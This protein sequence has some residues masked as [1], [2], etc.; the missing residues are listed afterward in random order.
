[1]S[2]S[3]SFAIKMTSL[4]C[5]LA[6]AATWLIPNNE[7]SGAK[8]NVQDTMSKPL[9]Q[10]AAQTWKFFLAATKTPTSL[11]VDRIDIDN[12]GTP[13]VAGSNT[14]PTNIGMY[15]MSLAAA[16]D[17]GLLSSGE[18]SK[19]LD[20]V[21]K[22]IEHL[23]KWNGFLYNWYDTSDGSVA[24]GSNARFV[25]TVDN[26]WY[27]AGLIVAR[28]AF[29]QFSPRLT[30][31]F[32]AMD[33]SRLYDRSI[34]QMYGGF[35][36]E[37]NTLADW[38]YGNLNTESRVADYVAIGQGHVPRELWWKVYRTLP[39]DWTW[40]LQVPKGKFAV[41]DG[42]SVFEGH[43]SWGKTNFVP[44]WGGSMFE[45]LMPTL[46]LDERSLA[47]KGFGLN[48]KR[49]VDLQIQY[50]HVM[51]YPVWGISPCATPNDGYGVYGVQQ[52]ATSKYS[53]DGTITPHASFLALGFEPS[54]AYQNL[55]TMK[56]KYPIMGPY[57]FFDSLNVKTKTVTR[58]YLTLDE[59][60]ILV[61]IDNYVNHGRIQSYF[62][63]DPVG[64]NPRT[65]LTGEDFYIQ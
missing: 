54:T 4:G 61:S 33:F 43:Y 55:E 65:L 23:E 45:A 19:R 2:L 27:A 49:M 47:P 59:G 8:I 63:K 64:K 11:P 20:S 60:M 58:S 42:V 18:M 50:A 10:W 51:H 32:Q 25:S 35:D 16:K 5:F 1:M 30:K 56:G 37:K 13:I 38:H 44:S 62:M 41:H 7:A 24:S 17:L 6:F 31:L 39:A 53:E 48:D 3:R 52:L 28:E 29:P 26:G 57:G 36:A 15:L 22:S 9:R 12:R 46:V 34:G 40:Q 21:L 14:S